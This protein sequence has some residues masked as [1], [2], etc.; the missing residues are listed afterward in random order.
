MIGTVIRI[1]WLGLLRD[2]VALA[3][4][5]AMPLAFFSIFAS[6]FGAMDTGHANPIDAVVLASRPSEA[7]LRLEQLLQADANVRVPTDAGPRDVDQARELI[8]SGRVQAVVVL[9][10]DFAEALDDPQAGPARVGLLA[11]TAN[12]IA[13]QA[14]KGILQAAALQV[15][16]ERITEGGVQSP[17]G[18]EQGV[19]L[20]DVGVVEVSVED[21]LGAEGKRPSVAFFAAGL[22]VMFLLF[23]LSGRA[24][25]LLEERESGVLVRVM[26]TRLGLNRLLAGR[27]LFLTALGFVQ[28]TAMFVWGSLVFGLELWTARHLA[29]F[30]VLTAVTSAA[31]A[32][33]AVLLATACR[34]RA[35]LTGVSVVLVL[36]MSALG[37]SMFPRFLMPEQLRTLGRLTFNAWALDGYQKVFWYERTVVDLLPELCVLGALVAAFLLAAR[38]I[39]VRTL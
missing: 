14:V 8:R 35:Q 2:P 33:F 36:V 3:L 39:A 37:G 27:W 4:T 25:L 6:V 5:F 34:T 20:L 38:L 9:P 31:A 18:R 30:C 17:V 21:V 32:A 19:G 23:S 11:D 7:A 15:A 26:A 24:G 1:G 10:E 28:V 29:G 13:V 22:G 16:L 12:P